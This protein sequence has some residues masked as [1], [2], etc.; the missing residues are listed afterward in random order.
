VFFVSRQPAFGASVASY[1]YTAERDLSAMGSFL[2]MG[3]IGLVIAGLVNIF[4]AS[5]QHPAVRLSDV[6]GVL[7]ASP[8]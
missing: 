1:G 2:M 6:V 4:L 5:E 7:R 8:A 3:L